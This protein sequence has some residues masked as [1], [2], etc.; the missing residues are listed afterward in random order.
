MKI[1]RILSFILCLVLVFC[2][3]P[4]VTSS[5]AKA[6]LWPVP[7]HTQLSRGWVPSQNHYAID[8]NDGSIN[9]APVVA[10]IGGQIVAIYKCGISP[11]TLDATK[12]SCNGFGWG[13]IIHGDDGR[14]Y[15]YAHMQAN[16]F[17]GYVYY[18]ARIETGAQVGRV[19]STGASTGPHL[20]F[21]INT[22]SAYKGKVNPQ[23]ETY[24]Y[25]LDELVN[26]YLDVN[27]KV[28]DADKS[29]LDGVATFDVYINGE[30]VKDD[31]TNYYVR[32][33]KGTKYEIN[34]LKINGCYVVTGES[35]F[36]GTHNGETNCVFVFETKHTLDEGVIT[37][38]PTCTQK[39][40]MTVSCS[41]CDYKTTSEVD[42]LGHDYKSTVTK[43]TCTEN[44]KEIYT[45]TRCSDSY[46]KDLG[47]E[48]SWSDWSTEKPVG[49]GITVQESVQYRCY[50]KE[51]KI[52]SETLGEDWKL[53]SSKWSDGEAK[54][55]SYVKSWPAGFSK[56]NGLYSQYNNAAPVATDTATKKIVVGNS[57]VQGYIYW[58][59]CSSSYNGMSMG[60]RFINDVYTSWDNGTSRSY[61]VFHAFY[62]TTY[63]GVDASAGAVK[64]ENA[65]GCSHVYWWQPALEVV[66]TEYTE[67][68]LINEYTRNT[69]WSEWS[70]EEVQASDTRVVETRTAYRFADNSVFATGHSWDEGKK[71]ADGSIVYICQQ[72][73]E[74]SKVQQDV[75]EPSQEPDTD[76]TD[77]NEPLVVMTGDINGDGKVTAS[78]ARAA[79]RISANLVIPDETQKLAADVNG[80]G[81]VTASDARKI[82]RV[83]ASLDSFDK[84]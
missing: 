76:I 52:T 1:K 11:H 63:K 79:L 82:L 73:G 14:W 71:V 3:V 35:S 10:A 12:C 70:E 9:G 74:T 18:G 4:P 37:T 26:P 61:D 13:I 49:D 84:K 51:T 50:D 36:A 69:E 21:E 34:D 45:C 64:Y 28:D 20:H 29:T 22:Q 31:V 47:E 83:S 23:N 60:N 30:K 6:L 5:A 39:G 43:P 54:S 65:S 78:D 56:S 7:G 59:W 27:A 68:N 8:I 58:H 16:S 55:V 15:Q 77:N 48:I 80:D 44:S 62:S 40:E 46:E 75:N 24:V 33:P 42:S 67:Y 81:K 72:C 41:V 25:S 2:M 17:P 66:K 38:D 19:G 53:V 32:H 57:S